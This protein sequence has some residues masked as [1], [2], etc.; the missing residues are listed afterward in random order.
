VTDKKKKDAPEVDPNIPLSQLLLDC[1]KDKYRMVSL[2]TRWAI[3]VG[4]R[5]PNTIRQPEE[6]VSMALREILTG[7]VSLADIEKLPPAPK[8]EKKFDMGPALSEELTKKLAEEDARAEKA[9]A[10]EADKA[11]ADEEEEEDEE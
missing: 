3:E 10:K 8:V 6:L 7:Q 5:D 2:A 9:R 1:G 4:G 11:P